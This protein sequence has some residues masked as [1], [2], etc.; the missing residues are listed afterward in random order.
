MV[1]D[2]NATSHGGLYIN[3]RPGPAI[4]FLDGIRMPQRTPA[5]I[6]GL[7]E[8]TYTV[9]LSLDQTDPF[10]RE[11]SDIKFTDQEVYVHPSCIV[12]VDVAANSSPLREIIIDSRNLRGEQFT[13]NGHAIRKT[14]PDKIAATV[15]ESFITIF[16]NQSYVSFRFP[17]TLNDDRYLMFESREHYDLSIFVDS[18]PRGAEV[19]ID[20]FRTGFSTPYSFSNISDGPH[21]IMVS[22][23]GFIPQERIIDLLYTPVPLPTTDV[24]FILEEYPGGFLK[25]AS[26]PPGAAITFD[27]KDTGEV[28]PLLFSSV[29]IGLHTVTVSGD[30]ITR[31][32]PDITVNSVNIVN[33]SADLNEI[34]E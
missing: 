17:V 25:V 24:S 21:R 23:P 8:G 5:V 15:S 31:K 27:G 7:K 29:P 4:I 19:F 1:P 16:Y 13:V 18:S 14:I 34:P 30:T 10:L 26:D 20:G 22:K 33:I 32:Y 28:T 9:R 12:P 2:R 3:S 11:K 6:Q